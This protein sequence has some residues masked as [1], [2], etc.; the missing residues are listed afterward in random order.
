MLISLFDWVMLSIIVAAAA[1]S[2]RS[3]KLTLA[4][5]LSGGLVAVL[6]YFGTGAPGLL[7]LAVFFILGTAVTSYK[8]QY[9]VNLQL[10]ALEDRK[11][12]TGQVFANG[13]VPAIIGLFS[14]IIAGDRT[15]FEVMVAGSLA[16]A[17]G[18]TFSSELGNVYGRN[19]FIS[20]AAVVNQNPS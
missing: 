4:A 19:F 15:V 20:I 12:T 6:I 17:T 9:K 1:Y 11:R 10:A 14:M 18:D 5:A 8:H 2:Y 7:M 3:N 16:A 13:G